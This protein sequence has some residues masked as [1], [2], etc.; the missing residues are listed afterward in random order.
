M[1]ELSN[2]V[3]ALRTLALSAPGDVLA[4]PCTT[5]IIKLLSLAIALEAAGFAVAAMLHA[6][7]SIFGVTETR[8]VSEAIVQSI[9]GAA[10]A[11]SA[12]AIFRRRPWAWRSALILHIFGLL[13]FV[14]GIAQYVAGAGTEFE[15]R[16]VYNQ[17]RVALLVVVFAV[18]LMP[19]VR[20]LITR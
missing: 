8:G 12:Y 11:T 14:F 6:G 20:S 15:L 2:D 13:G 19:R 7:V 17:V 3:E 1:S 10:F 4:I 16:H 5:L 18:L 9:L